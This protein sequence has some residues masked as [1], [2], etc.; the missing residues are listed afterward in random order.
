MDYTSVMKFI[1]QRKPYMHVT[2]E[3]TTPQNCLQCKAYI[4]RIYAAS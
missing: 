2:L 1:K 3:E 4:E